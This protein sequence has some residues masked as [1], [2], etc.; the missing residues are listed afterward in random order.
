MKKIIYIY[1]LVGV[2]SFVKVFAQDASLR[3][4]AELHFDNEEWIEALENYDLL[5]QQDPRDTKAYAE[6]VISA[7][8]IA[9]YHTVSEFMVKAETYHIPPHVLL[10]EIDR[11]TRESGYPMLYETLLQEIGDRIPSW[12]PMTDRYLLEFY[13]FRHQDMQVIRM[14][15]EITGGETADPELL[16]IK[17]RALY[18]TGHDGEALRCY[19][20]VMEW[21]PDDPEPYIFAGNYYYLQGT[22]KLEDARTEYDSFSSPTRMQYGFYKRKQREVMKN[23]YEKAMRYLETADRIKPSPALKKTLYKIYV[24]RADV[25]RAEAVKR[26]KKK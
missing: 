5:L 17:A 20:K 26:S 16:K 19:E 7:M 3:R 22:K 2:C 21:S 9:D 13:R 15:D 14:I 10:P 25:T 12:K 23:E 6:A 4:K 8:K 1:L 24:Q 11:T 18:N